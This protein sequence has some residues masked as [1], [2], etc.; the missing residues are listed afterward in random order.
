[1]RFIAPTGE[2]AGLS[3]AFLDSNAA[4][5]L[6]HTQRVVRPYHFTVGWNQEPI[7]AGV[8]NAV[9]LFLSTTSGNPVNDMGDSLK[10][11]VIFG[12][13]KMT[14]PLELPFDP[15]AGERQPGE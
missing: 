15:D 9:V 10:V 7:Y 13:Q 1:D 2:A 12:S 4:Q 11:E 3:V 6:T 8:N 14:L 5:A